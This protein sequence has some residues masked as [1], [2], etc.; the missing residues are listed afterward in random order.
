M[1]LA[2]NSLVT[3]IENY[4]A[5]RDYTTQDAE[6]LSRL[7][8]LEYASEKN[9]L[10][11]SA[12]Q[13]P[14][15][16]IEQVIDIAIKHNLKAE[17]SEWMVFAANAVDNVLGYSHEGIIASGIGEYT[18]FLPEGHPSRTNRPAMTASVSARSTALWVAGDPRIA[19][20][21]ARL[22]V[23]NAY[24][25]KPG[26]VEAEYAGAKLSALVSSGY[27]PEDVILP[28]TAAFKM[29][30]AMRSAIAKALAA[31]RRRHGDGRFAEEFG[32]LKGFFG[33]KDGSIFSSNGRIVGAVPN[34]NNFEVSFPG[35]AD[36]PKGVYTLDASRTA[37]L[38]AVLSKRALKNVK[39]LK[40]TDSIDMP[41]ESE[42]RMAVSLDE[43]LATRK[44][45]PSGWTKN[46]DGSFTSKSGQTSRVVETAPEGDYM[47]EGIGEGNKIDPAQPLFELTDKD[48]KTLGVAQDWAGLNK[49]GMSYDALNGE[50][51]TAPEE[52]GFDQS[53]GGSDRD[54][55]I[56][57]L[58]DGAQVWMDDQ[59]FG[60]DEYD[61]ASENLPDPQ[62]TADM[63]LDAEKSG[64]TSELEE[65]L[66]D[67]ESKPEAAVIN[68]AI[69]RIKGDNGFDQK[70]GE[71]Q[72]W[73]DSAIDFDHLT[74]PKNWTQFKDGNAEYTSPD[75]KLVLNWEADGE[76][77]MGSGMRDLSGVSVEYDG[78]P[79]G[80]FR[81]SQRD[82]EEGD[83][84]DGLK[85]LLKKN[86]WFSPDNLVKTEDDGNSYIFEGDSG[87]VEVKKEYD[88][89]TKKTKFAVSKEASD[90][91]DENREASYART[92]KFDS[93][94]EALADAEKFAEILNDP[95]KLFDLLNESYM[96]EPAGL[97]QKAGGAKNLP[98]MA[99]DLAEEIFYNTEGSTGT[100]FDGVEF[101]VSDADSSGDFTFFLSDADGNKI[102]SGTFNVSN[103]DLGMLADKVLP[104]LESR[105]A[106]KQ[107]ESDG[108]DQKAGDTAETPELGEE[109][110]AIA[111]G[112]KN[113]DFFNDGDG[114]PVDGE[115]FTSPDGRVKVTYRDGSW[116]EEE[117]GFVS[118]DEMAVSVDGKRVDSVVRKN[119]ESWSD[120]LDRAAGLSEVGIAN[121]N[122]ADDKKAKQE[123]DR[124]ARE[125]FEKSPDQVELRAQRKFEREQAAMA[126]EQAREAVDSEGLLSKV[127]D[128]AK[129]ISN[130][131]SDD[132]VVVDDVEDERGDRNWT[133]YD[134]DGKAI[135]RG[136]VGPNYDTKDI[137][138]DLRDGINE[139]L[140][141]KLDALE[142]PAG[143][144]QKAG[145]APAFL[146]EDP[147]AIKLE[148][149]GSR[150]LAL[151]YTDPESRSSGDIQ[152]SITKD[153]KGNDA[154]VSI[155][156]FTRGEGEGLTRKVFT[157]E[158]TRGDFDAAAQKY[159]RK[160]IA[161]DNKARNR[162]K[163]GGPSPKQMEP[164]TDKQYALLEELNSERDD[165]DPVT[166]EAIN[167]ALSGRNMSKAQ[168]SSLFGELQK[169]PFKPGV[170]PTKPTD[171]QID[172]LQGY[173]TT[174][175][176]S[177]E[178]MTDILDQLDAG[179]D[180]AG[181]E[182]LTSKLRRRPDRE[183]GFNQ[184]AGGEFRTPDDE[185]EK[186]RAVAGKFADEGLQEK[187]SK[188]RAGKPDVGFSIPVDPE[189]PYA[190]INVAW[191]PSEG[192]WYAFAQ[193][194]KSRGSTG[195][196]ENGDLGDFDTPEE[197]MA[198][199]VAFKNDPD[200]MEA[201]NQ[202][203]EEVRADIDEEIR[204]DAEDAIL[205][206]D[207]AQLEDYAA[208]GDFEAYHDRINDALAELENTD[209]LGG[210]DQKAGID[211]EFDDEYEQAHET[212]SSRIDEA[213]DSYESDLVDQGLSSSEIFDKMNEASE[214]AENLRDASNIADE[215]GAENATRNNEVNGIFD[216]IISDIGKNVSDLEDRKRT[217]L[218]DAD[219]AKADEVQAAID[220]DDA[221][222]LREL[223]DNQDYSDYQSEIEDALADIN[224]RG[225]DEVPGF[226]QSAGTDGTKGLAENWDTA[227]EDT[228]SAAVDAVR[229]HISEMLTIAPMRFF[230]DFFDY[231]K[232][233]EDGRRV[234]EKPRD[235]A[236]DYADYLALNDPEK[237]ESILDGQGFDPSD[238]DGF[239][240]ATTKAPSAKMSEPATEA[241][242]SYLQNLAETKMD[243]D[244]ETAKAIQE[245]LDNKNLTKSQAGG[246]IGKLR[247]LGNKENVGQ[248][249]KP[250][251]RMIDSVNRDVYMKGLSDEDREAF[252]D[253]LESQS[254]GDVSTIISQL[255][256]LPDVDGGMEK[257]IDS[258]VA[259]NDPEA[260][261]RLLAD[262][263]YGRWS[264][265]MKDGLAKMGVEPAGFDQSA[266][267]PS[268]DFQPEVDN[269]R[270]L[271][272]R[273]VA[274]DEA[275]ELGTYNFISKDS[276]DGIDD[277]FEAYNLLSELDRLYFGMR[278][279]SEAGKQ[280]EADI[281]EALDKLE[282]DVNA[283]V[284]LIE[285][286]KRNQADSY[287]TFEFDKAVNDLG[288]L[289]EYYYPTSASEDMRTGDGGSVGDV[290]GG[291]WESA[292]LFNEE[293]EKWDAQMTSPG[294]V[295]ESYAEE[296]DDQDEA[297]SWIDD[298][299]ST[300]NAMA[301]DRDTKILSEDG[302]EGLVKEY[303]DDPEKLADI[304]D[305]IS[306]WLSGTGRG[307]V[308]FSAQ[309][310]FEYSDRLRKLAAKNPK[311]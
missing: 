5:D 38:K 84:E 303:G 279:K 142:P 290:R 19:S 198:A 151:S 190:K 310:L 146:E 293:T 123:A 276:L 254:K 150:G 22:D 157:A 116:I 264:S 76:P 130:D 172:S 159:L 111:Q 235:Y 176:L 24:A 30:F 160:L 170:D 129:R 283:K 208:D 46:E 65:S 162:E 232:T 245:A 14:S 31:V 189:D 54:A 256:D 153:S 60:P 23:Y 32:R 225:G 265:Q 197:A 226:N 296:F 126:Q 215:R 18:D 222:F 220:G 93:K 90:L 273:I 301:A 85:D 274:A 194:Q 51:E 17:P 243:I 308:K 281:K 260:L 81:A 262:E 258:L 145:D 98:D 269:L 218:A 155:V 233:S 28:I 135:A 102:G 266:G 136:M 238:F 33:R 295:D 41:T 237:L 114:N 27:V 42:K 44:D 143:L 105:M 212:I 203:R 112:L 302:L 121:P 48:G 261:Q 52:P 241:Q 95:S 217:N 193:I 149:K 169:K 104:L 221:S 47:T 186:A 57:E 88:P 137:T 168:I 61:A 300:Q 167:D 75:G 228:K 77:D 297:A 177:P 288:D 101:H 250:S 214:V 34:T 117:K 68:K 127:D 25:T 209:E 87:F 74:D 66:K 286:A 36:I 275:G 184:S 2:F 91:I 192:K 199:A 292:L 306:S 16:S 277:E 196:S 118:W 268:Y 272:D 53:A 108:F 178:E 255:K 20:D 253:K 40:P 181:M 89:A 21:Q 156:N 158:N 195:S 249:G 13:V 122:Y 71:G 311:A 133:L 141:E 7:A 113:H 236:D 291:G 163:S 239:D 128:F 139:H 284:G 96:D 58:E 211:S 78:Q 230:Q 1:S 69:E 174:K 79:V 309:K 213:L 280:L 246:F 257:Y 106:R 147:K 55:L 4:Y 227:D 94:E 119:R 219:Q 107:G 251:Q 45:A 124:K 267:K 216:S 294:Q 72:S 15:D 173:L 244:P 49:I 39:G 37:S 11:A 70:A 206:G 188:F 278:P 287:D 125:D 165:I 166:Q 304:I 171:R 263:R 132:S 63:I 183:G 12:R 259:K 182:A 82:L 43:F 200:R 97:D 115:V 109:G 138:S 8:I 240:Q 26:S 289:F 152:R 191:G 210:F 205:T 103:D 201:Y 154:K 56:K 207:R 299:L 231:A 223:L 247:D 73:A 234:F 100:D 9:A 131:Q 83:I 179:L 248:Y 99:G 270:D 229:S 175:D 298:Q 252:L 185:I 271:V 6:H 3:K 86:S 202:E 164:A 29:N 62:V 204:I 134:E 305:G 67:V 285:A 59:R 80:S 224:A 64:D 187:T 92:N 307:V 140:D 282:T 161:D 120:F 10:V 35:D 242:Y 110:K 180:R 148:E 144:D 50:G